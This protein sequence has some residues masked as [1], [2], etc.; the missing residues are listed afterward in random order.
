MKK[1]SFY[2]LLIVFTVP[3]LTSCGPAFLKKMLKDH[4]EIIT[5]SIKSNPSVYMEALAEAQRKFMLDRRKKQ[6]EE[7]LASREEEFKNPKKPDTPAS[8]VYFG[9]KNA[10]IT[11]VEYSD[12]QCGYCA[13]AVK[14]LKRVLS[15]YPDKVRV[16]YK[17]KPIFPGSDKAAMYYEAIGMQS[18]KKAR[19]FH[20]MVFER[21]NEIRNG[22]KFFKELAQKLKV[23]MSK[24][25]K[26]LNL[27]EDIVNADKAE[28]EKF[29]FSGTPGFLIGGVS[30][31]GALP[32]SEFKKII[33]RHL[34]MS[35][36]GGK[37]KSVDKEKSA[38]A[39]AD[40]SKS[41]DKE[42]ES[43]D[44]GGA[45]DAKPSA[46]EGAGPAEE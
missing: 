2:L 39:P 13:K 46:E 24:L 36:G 3:F 18:S 7:E 1:T 4:P 44:A 6:Q 25:N 27:V 20:D 28:A 21:K 41:A 17:H 42:V 11:I 8:R 5:E 14:T 16:L 22:D 26:D 9:N 45:K 10:P 15:A 29:G 32:F 33:D 12:F 34:S 19:D 37:S 40:E 23:D 38:D 30:V 35:D 31:P 43:A